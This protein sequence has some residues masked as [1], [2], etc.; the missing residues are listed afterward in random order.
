ML[1]RYLMAGTL[2]AMATYGAVL[3]GHL[4][5]HADRRLAPG[6]ATTEAR[7][8]QQRRMASAGVGSTAAAVT[9]ARPRASGPPSWIRA[10]NL[11]FNQAATELL[12]D[13]EPERSTLIFTFGSVSMFDFLHNWLHHVRKQGLAPAVVGAADVQ[14]LE[15]C[16]KE[17]IAA[18]GIAPGLDV[19][20]YELSRNASTVVQTGKSEWKYYR[21]HKSSFLELGLVKAAFLWELLGTA[22]GGRDAVLPRL[23][24]PPGICPPGAS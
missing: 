8:H 12:V 16:A 19:W 20:T 10:S 21:H 22:A 24:P 18:A 14:M 2:I 13:H 3:I 6:S 5:D 17:S 9:P 23:T 11:V 15:A 1:A 4:A 7:H